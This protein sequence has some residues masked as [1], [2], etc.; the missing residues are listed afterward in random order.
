MENLKQL[1][2]VPPMSE[3]FEKLNEV[4]VAIADDEKIEITEIFTVKDLSSMVSTGQSLVIF[5][6]AKSC[7]LFLQE[8]KF[9]IAKF[10]T[11]VILLIP[12]ELPKKT[13]QKFLKLG[14]TEAIFEGSPPKTL[15]NKV[16]MLLRSIKSAN[17]KNEQQNQVVTSMHNLNIISSTANDIS[18]VK[19]KNAAAE[20]EYLDE[21]NLKGDAGE[22][23]DNNGELK[24]DHDLKADRTSTSWNSKRKMNYSNL[25]IDNNKTS[26]KNERKKNVYYPIKKKIETSLRTM[27][28]YGSKKRPFG[29]V[30]NN[31]APRK[32]GNTAS[33][34]FNKK[35]NLKDKRESEGGC[36]DPAEL[37]VETVDYGLGSKFVKKE[38]PH[39]EANDEKSEFDGVVDTLSGDVN[40]KLE[41]IFE[42][43]ALDLENELDKTQRGLADESEKNTRSDEDAGYRIEKKSKLQRK[44]GEGEGPD[45]EGQ[46]DQIY[47]YGIKKNKIDKK[48]SN[49][50]FF[51][52]D[53]SD[54]LSSLTMVGVKNIHKAKKDLSEEVDL[55][56]DK[57]LDE[58][59]IDTERARKNYKVVDDG[60]EN[61]REESNDDEENFYN[62]KNQED[63]FIDMPKNSQKRNVADSEIDS[64][65][66]ESNSL[67][68]DGQVS[69][70]D[71]NSSENNNEDNVGND[72]SSEKD[73]QSNLSQNKNAITKQGHG[74]VNDLDVSLNS[75]RE[76]SG[77]SWDI[78]VDKNE[79]DSADNR[80]KKTPQVN[81]EF[82]YLKKDYKEQTIDYHKI[83]NEFEKKIAINEREDENIYSEENVEEVELP[84]EENPKE[85][86]EYDARGVVFSIG[87][88]KLIYN[89]Y[90]VD[91]DYFNAI[92]KELISQYKAY[93][94]FYTY[95]AV[96]N[97]YLEIFNTFTF[98]DS[99]AS[100][101]LKESWEI[102]KSNDHFDD[103]FTKTMPT[104]QCRDIP[105]KSKEGKFWED[106][107]LPRWAS[108]EMATKKM[109]LVFP[110]FDGVDFMGTAIVF[111]SE[112]VNASREK[113]III[114]LDTA[115][116][117]LLNSIQRKSVIASESAKSNSAFEKV[118]AC[119]GF[120][121]GF[122]N[123]VKKKIK[124]A[125]LG[126]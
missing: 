69:T 113:S 100:E 52:E 90:S 1:V 28:E 118:N 48:S 110:Y 83:K 106:I 43:I 3:A 68:L 53:L 51:D 60:D 63:I 14:L 126:K 85:V 97:K 75:D 96:D 98:D 101:D 5:S 119:L 124:E 13:L 25:D 71:D 49:E 72:G 15:L 18:P 103:C 47:E 93:V 77:Y 37:P 54:D 105:D 31:L 70:S 117:V 108:N 9:L 42:E 84:E 61:S 23:T 116:T 82:S 24:G 32:P 88:I 45:D 115:R 29:N 67:N 95:E 56:K 99:G 112:G 33:L 123:T 22:R 50:G 94:V 111:F 86:I 87:I 17:P 74:K 114:T 76:K 27:S 34:S 102:I 62:K 11:K 91:L 40:S 57:L 7:A 64:E 46:S 35:Q 79:S 78:L 4:L 92:S 30:A 65:D 6:N 41:K 8:N 73:N 2:V 38:S 104:W 109:E 44:F 89:Q 20:D 39:N 55:K 81:L 12:K 26:F 16:K 36:L 10:H 59:S 125:Y 120:V 58:N 80:R 66:N 122:F 19:Q 107:E 121:Y 21:Y